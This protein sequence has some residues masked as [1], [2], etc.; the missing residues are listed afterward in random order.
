MNS[1]ESTNR[2]ERTS[3]IAWLLLAILA[4]LL[5]HGTLY[6]LFRGLYVDFGKP[7]VD[8]I[9]PA[10]FHLERATI[11]PKHLEPELP[12]TQ[13]SN[14]KNSREPLEMST[15]KIAAFD[16]PLKAPSIPLPRLT[17]LPTAPL[18]NGPAPLPA[19]A[20]TALPIHSEG[21]IPEAAQALANEASTAAMAEANKALAQSN[22]G[23]NGDAM[24]SSKGT[25]GFSEIS[26]L[27]NLRPPSALER[28][29]FQPI[30]IRL[31]S[32]VLFEFD[33]ARLKTDAESSLG[34]VAAVLAQAKK[35]QI[36]VEGH[37]DTIGTDEYNQ[38]LSEQRA[39]AVAV[40]LRQRSGLGPDVLHSRGFGKTRPIVNPRGSIEEQA[41]NRRVEIRVEGER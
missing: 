37:T 6:I 21:G 28:P 35:V 40:W 31:S 24:A 1:F 27:A 16:G 33:S 32:D 17:N 2:S 11:D 26:S 19:E 41:R 20:F 4:S 5:L 12:P 3:F 29:G 18:G 7:L 39:E 22:P 13:G 38:R 36:M 8:P 23:G 25:P 34:Q 15:E 10:R 9:E 14:P 30:L